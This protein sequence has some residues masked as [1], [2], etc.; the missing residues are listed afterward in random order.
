MKKAIIRY[1]EEFYDRL[2]APENVI[3]SGGAKQA[4]MVALQA[5]LNPQEEVIFPA[6]F[7]VSYPEM[8]RLCGSVP[9]PAV[10][11]DGTD[12]E[13]IGATREARTNAPRPT[14]QH[15][16]ISPCFINT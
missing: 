16:R 13:P 12:P 14:T 11:E 1:T 3:A 7:W 9:V 15:T 10:P 2:V 6:S 8:V 4:I 5:I